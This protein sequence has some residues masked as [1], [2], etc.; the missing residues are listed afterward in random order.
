MLTVYGLFDPGIYGP[1]VIRYVGCTSKSVARR[2]SQHI[3]EAK[4]RQKNARH[5]WLASLIS[6]GERPASITLEVTDAGSWPNREQYWIAT[7][8][9]H[10]LVNSTSGG[11]GLTDPTPEVRAVISEK[12]SLILAGN[13][14]RVGVPHSPEVRSKISAGLLSSERK[15]AFDASRKGRTGR[16]LTEE[17]KARISAANSGRKHPE[18]SQEWR[19]RQRASHLGKKQSAETIAKRAEKQI[20][21]QRSNGHRHSDEARARIAEVRRGRVWI[22]DGITNKQTEKGSLLPDGWR[23]G[24]AKRTPP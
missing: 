23:F 11:V 17:E 5:R 8:S 19:D 16:K 20:G 3:H 18:R 15:R 12:V 24:R 7:L 10:G 13:A 21:N 4:E 9:S 14:R 2:I 22:T 1:P 6:R